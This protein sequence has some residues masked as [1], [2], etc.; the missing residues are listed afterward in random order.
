MFI[1]KCCNISYKYNSSLVRHT[2]LNHVNNDEI[3]PQLNNKKRF[4]CN[5][6]NKT[7]SRNDALK[8]HKIKCTLN[9]VNLISSQTNNSLVIAPVQNKKINCNNSTINNIVI[10]TLGNENLAKLTHNE[11]DRIFDDEINGVAQIENAKH[12]HISRP[13]GIKNKRCL[14]FIPDNYMC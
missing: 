11:I 2:K 3:T 1:C 14:F 8:I 10:N 12:F 5:N 13:Q 9:N 4:Y 6:C 7:F